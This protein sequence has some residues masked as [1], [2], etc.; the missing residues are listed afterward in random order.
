ML[1]FAQV[2]AYLYISIEINRLCYLFGFLFLGGSYLFA[3]PASLLLVL[4]I[5][6]YECCAKE[7]KARSGVAIIA[8]A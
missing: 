7:D 2:L 6:A 5:A 8:T 3:V 4:L 1:A